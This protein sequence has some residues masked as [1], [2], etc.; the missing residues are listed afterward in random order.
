MSTFFCI[1]FVAL[2]TCSPSG[3]SALSQYRSL[4]NSFVAIIARFQYP[5]IYE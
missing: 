3:T 5:L 4:R 1:F 2:S